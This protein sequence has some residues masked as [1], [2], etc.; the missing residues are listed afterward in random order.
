M[1]QLTDANL[2]QIAAWFHQ[3]VPCKNGVSLF[4]VIAELSA[5]NQATAPQAPAP[6]AVEV[7]ENTV[8]EAPIEIAE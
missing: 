4:D 5:A 7:A 2:K 1:Y 8:E 3:D 6:E